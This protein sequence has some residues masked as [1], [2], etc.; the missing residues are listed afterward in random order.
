MTAT[1]PEAEDL[2]DRA[3]ADLWAT[4]E[5]LFLMSILLDEAKTTIP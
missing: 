5:F 2:T 3:M 1:T 4:Q